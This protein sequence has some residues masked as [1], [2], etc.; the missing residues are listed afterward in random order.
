MPCTTVI[1]IA[2]EARLRSLMGEREYSYYI[3]AAQYGQ[4]MYPQMFVRVSGDPNVL[5]EPLRRRLQREMPGAAYV[6]VRP[7]SDLVDPNLRGWRFGATMFVV[8]GAIALVLAAIGLY[9]MIAYAV[10]Q[11]TRELGV[12]VALGA[13]AG[14]VLRLIVRGGVLLVAAGIALGGVIALWAAPKLASLMFEVSTR[15]PL[16]YGTM[17]AV[18]LVTA[19]V[20]SLA[21]AIRAVRLNPNAALRAD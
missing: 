5:V 7:L 19:V 16:V 14:D 12:R 15:D 3:P 8:F 17:A 20:A 21:P 6:N 2:E 18:L 10:A 9:S 13:T 4:P 11:R 1:G